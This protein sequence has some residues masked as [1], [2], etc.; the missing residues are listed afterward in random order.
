[1]WSSGKSLA[2]GVPMTSD[3][4]AAP[5]HPGSRLAVPALTKLAGS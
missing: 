1:M 3:D 5:P 2:G 4:E